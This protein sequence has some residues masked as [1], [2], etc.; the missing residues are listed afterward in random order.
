MAQSIVNP[1]DLSPSQILGRI[2]TLQRL[3]EEQGL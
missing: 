2:A 3:L 1:L